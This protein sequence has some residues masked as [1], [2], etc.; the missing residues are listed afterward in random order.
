M[1]LLDFF[2]GKNE[3]EMVTLTTKKKIPKKDI[4]M[5]IVKVYDSITKK[6]TGVNPYPDDEEPHQI[7][8]KE[9]IDDLEA[10]DGVKCDFYNENN[11]WLGTYW[12]EKNKNVVVNN[13]PTMEGVVETLNKNQSEIDEVRQAVLGDGGNSGGDSELEVLQNFKTKMQLY[14]EITGETTNTPTNRDDYPM[15]ARLMADKE[16]REGFKDMLEDSVRSVGKAFMEGVTDGQVKQ[17]NTQTRKL[18]K[19]R[20]LPAPKIQKQKPVKKEMEMKVIDVPD[21][22]EEE[23]KV[24]VKA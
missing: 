12:K 20:A 21:E 5:S 1:A 10:Y 17:S 9:E 15:Y 14:R 19:R 18:L 23:K 13:T 8:E 7:V 22:K 4:F 24:E 3:E 2:K 11:K 16:V 6:W